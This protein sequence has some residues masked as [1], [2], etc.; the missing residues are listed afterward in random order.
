VHHLIDPR[1]GEPGRGGLVAVTVVGE[2]PA[3][4]EVWSKALFLVGRDGIA[5]HAAARG[6]AALWVDE[7]G[8]VAMTDS[9]TDYVI[10]QV[11]P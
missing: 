3:T 1:T 4:S 5:E 7:D 6:L 8:E 10:W 2:Q 9:M 11:S